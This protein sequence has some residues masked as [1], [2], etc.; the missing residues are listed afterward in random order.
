MNQSGAEIKDQLTIDTKVYFSEDKLP[1]VVK[2]KNE[3][4]AIL[5]KPYPQKNT[6]WYTIIDW[7]RGV[8]GPNNLVFNMYNYSLQE[9][10]DQ[11]LIDLGDENN[12]TEVSYRHCIGI[13][14]LK[15][16]QPEK[17]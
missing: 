4:F 11:C 15:I 10:I 16:K 2:A 8:R 12:V 1:Y 5:T 7:K 14:I 3:N 17:V 6:V 9:D 13:N